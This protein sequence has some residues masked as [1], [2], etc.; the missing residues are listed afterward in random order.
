MPE[1]TLQNLEE[2]RQR[3]EKLE[4]ILSEHQ[5]LGK[6]DS[7]EFK[8]H[9]DLKAKSLVL[10]AEG[11]VKPGFYFLPINIFDQSEQQQTTQ[12]GLGIGLAVSGIKE[13]VGEQINVG[14]VSGKKIE[15]KDIPPVQSQIDFTKFNQT[16]IRIVHTPQ[17]TPSVIG[18]SL[19]PPSSFL[20]A[21]RTPIINARG[22]I[23]GGGNTLTDSQAKFAPNSL[24]GCILNIYTDGRVNLLEGYRIIGNDERTITIDGN[25]KQKSGSY[26]YK[27]NACVL[28]GSAA[29]PFARLYVG[30]DIRLGYGSSGGEE[31]R[32]IKW[33]Y[34]SPE[35]KV[36][37]NIGSL[38]LRF[39][40]GTNTTLYVKTDN[41]GQS[42]GWTAK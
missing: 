5:H 1:E 14:I 27:V 32:Y 34:G 11:E 3:I 12:R 13:S 10:A 21:E 20:I 18:P 28:L 19:F 41:N 36:A 38:Y 40:G 33:G 2:L 15:A 23:T 4:K 26:D 31:V 9:N 7:A 6:D 17:G 29:E 35:G 24:I 22:T 8:G 42:T 39:D 16:Q 30:E 25:W 37:A